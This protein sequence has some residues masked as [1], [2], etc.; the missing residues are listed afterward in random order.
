VHL[1]TGFILAIGS[2]LLLDACANH[3]S[4]RSGQASIDSASGA[5]DLSALPDPAIPAGCTELGRA[6]GDLDKD[7]QDELV[8]GYTGAQSSELGSMRRLVI[9]KAGPKSWKSWHESSGPLLPSQQ[10]GASGDPFQSIA[11]E[12]GAI[13]INHAGGSRERWDYVHR[14]RLNAAKW[15]LIGATI[16]TGEPCDTFT[17]LDFNLST[18]QVDLERESN[19]CDET[20]TE[21]PGQGEATTS[22]FRIGRSAVSMDGFQPG[23]NRIRIPDQGDFYY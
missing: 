23:E 16:T 14:Y 6:S 22:R 4:E 7:G 5:L 13:V 8:V 3:G 10:G 19:N 18:G 15:E 11:I 12:N 20:G 21:V 17:T 2:L 1:K 9:Y